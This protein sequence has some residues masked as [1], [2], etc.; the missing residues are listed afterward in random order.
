[1]T[2]KFNF[3]YL[4]DTLHENESKII[5]RRKQNN[6]PL[7]HYEEK[8][9]EGNGDFE[10]GAVSLKHQTGRFFFYNFVLFRLG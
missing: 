1:M 10:E 6:S 7:K 4:L 9:K 5:R 8:K 2:K 3:R